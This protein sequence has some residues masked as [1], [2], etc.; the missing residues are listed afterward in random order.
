MKMGMKEFRARVG[1]MGDAPEPVI[2][3]NHG[4]EVGTFIPR[5]WVRDAAAAERAAASVARWRKEM[6]MRGIDLN[7]ELA[8]MGMSPL[9]EPLNA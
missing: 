5:K 1:E 3:T 7:A 2:I 4:R 9:G 6:R 8:A